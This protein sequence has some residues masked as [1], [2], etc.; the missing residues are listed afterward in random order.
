MDHQ[1]T[2]EY[3]KTLT[4]LEGYEVLQGLKTAGSLKER[5]DSKGNQ[6]YSDGVSSGICYIIKSEPSLH[7]IIKISNSYTI[8]DYNKKGIFTE[9]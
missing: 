2:I 4:W 6:I 1:K 7:I 3:L 5:T 8:L 9:N